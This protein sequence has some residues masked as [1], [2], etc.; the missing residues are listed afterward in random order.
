MQRALYRALALD[1]QPDCV[2][3][4]GDLAD[5][6]AAEEYRVLHDILDEFPLPLHLAI[7][8]HD[9]RAA[10]IAAFAGTRYVNESARPSYAVDYLEATIVVLDSKDE[11]SAAGAGRLGQEQLD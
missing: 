4:T 10:F 8:S 6:G 7:G 1:P 5:H 11:H 9:D 2:V 3:I